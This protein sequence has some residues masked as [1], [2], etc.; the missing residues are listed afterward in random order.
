MK[1]TIERVNEWRRKTGWLLGFNYVPSTAVNTTEM[2]QFDTFD[3]ETIKREL[4]HAVSTGFNSCRVFLQ[5]LVWDNE[6]DQFLE[7]F[8]NFCDTA[9]SSGLSVM[10]I[11]FDDCA[12]AGKEPYLGAQ[13]KPKP[14]VHNSCWTPS[15]GPVISDDPSAEHNLREYVSSVIGAFANDRRIVI[16]DIY[17]EPGNN[18][19]SEKCLPLLEKAFGWARDVSPSQPLTAGVWNNDGYNN[20]FIELSD[21]ISYHDYLPVTDSKM[22]LLRLKQYKRPVYCTEWLHR[23]NGNIVECHLPLYGREIDG[24]YSWG[25]FTGKTQT[26]LRWQTMS[27]EPEANPE[28]WQQDLFYND[29]RPYREEEIAY[30]KRFAKEKIINC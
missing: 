5:Y 17:N 19:R 9:D 14:G 20:R 10:P 11:L 27:G 13:D 8:S 4:E 30:I 21:I 7:I 3:K 1:W 28:I 2:W 26:N 22:L 18:N 16:W 25:L 6:R 23:H 12:F 15:P 29:G 24:A